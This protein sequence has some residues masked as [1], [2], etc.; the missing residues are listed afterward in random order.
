MVEGY[1]PW[2]LIRA[3]VFADDCVNAWPIALARH[4]HEHVPN[5]DLE[6]V[7]QEFGVVHV[8]AVRAVPVSA[9]TGVHADAF[10][11]LGCEIREHAIDESHEIA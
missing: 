6:E 4:L 5:V 9:R 7:W 1:D 11:L 8:G 10:A 2:P 3:P